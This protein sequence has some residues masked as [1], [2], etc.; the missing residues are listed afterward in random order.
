MTQEAVN[1]K[2]EAKVKKA[3]R[4][5][6]EVDE[7]DTAHKGI[8]TKKFKSNILLR[9]LLKETATRNSRPRTA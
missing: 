1:R 8:G 4:K 3:A 5:R 6:A 2:L 7:D 9:E